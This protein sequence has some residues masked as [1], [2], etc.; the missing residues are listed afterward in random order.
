MK[1]LF[2]LLFATICFSAEAQEVITKKKPVRKT[3]KS[4]SKSNASK[5]P[6]VTS[7]N[8]ESRNGGMKVHEIDPNEVLDSSQKSK[9][10]ASQVNQNYNE[11][12]PPLSPLDGSK[13]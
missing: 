8:Y 9:L 6:V 12:M 2:F 7:M 5:I 4:K 1:Q 11:N 3:T 10:P 13:K